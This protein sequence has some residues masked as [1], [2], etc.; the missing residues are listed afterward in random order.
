M[1]QN[2]LQRPLVCVVNTIPIFQCLFKYSCVRHQF[3]LMVNVVHALSTCFLKFL[4][5][6]LLDADLLRSTNVLDQLYFNIDDLFSIKE[7]GCMQAWLYVEECI[8]FV[9][10]FCL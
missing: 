4:R 5:Y 10:M 2:E 1:N 8:T 6:C 3:I 9:E 7:E